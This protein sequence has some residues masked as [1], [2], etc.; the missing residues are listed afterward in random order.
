M[1]IRI[2]RQGSNVALYK[3]QPNSIAKTAGGSNEVFDIRIFALFITFVYCK[4]ANS[5]NIRRHEDNNGEKQNTVY[6]NFVKGAIVSGS[7]NLCCKIHNICDPTVIR[8]S[9]IILIGYV[10]RKNLTSILHVD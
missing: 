7:I 9:T 2:N 6:N 10:L 8:N 5:I 3:P 4:Q 1:L